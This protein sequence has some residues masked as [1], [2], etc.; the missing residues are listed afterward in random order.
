VTV[1]DRSSTCKEA[2]TAGGQ[3][4]PLGRVVFALVGFLC[5]LTF[6][7]ARPVYRLTSG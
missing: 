4:F 3:S 5:G 2:N 7:A 6:G 1:V